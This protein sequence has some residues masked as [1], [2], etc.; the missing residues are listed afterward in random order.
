M[1]QQMEHGL[2]H[3]FA[4]KLL[5]D[6]SDMAYAGVISGNNKGTI[7]VND[8]SNP[9]LCIAWSDFLEGF[10]FMGSDCSHV[11]NVASQKTAEK[12]GLTFSHEYDIFWFDL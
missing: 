3:S 5:N 6:H 4:D 1:I 8:I 10:H 12:V 11:G 2:N 9:T 7:W